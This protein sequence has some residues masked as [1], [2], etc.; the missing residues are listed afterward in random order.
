M[1]KIE[2]K[3]VA[4]SYEHQFGLNERWHIFYTGTQPPEP[5]LYRYVTP[6]YTHSVRT[7]T[8]D[9][10]KKAAEA[11]CVSNGMNPNNWQHN[12]KHIRAALEAALS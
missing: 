7:V 4:W 1:N 5:S 9:M 2:D 10:V 3:P 6:L 12:Q 8:D 11:Y